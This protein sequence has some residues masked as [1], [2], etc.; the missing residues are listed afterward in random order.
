MSIKEDTIGIY[1]SSKHKNYFL[2]ILRIL[3]DHQGEV[4]IF[5]QEEYVRDLSDYRIKKNKYTWVEKNK[6]ESLS[7]FLTRA[8]EIWN[9]EVN[10]LLV[11]PINASVSKLYEYYSTQFECTYV[12][13]IYNINLWTGNNYRFTHR[14]DWYLSTL[15]RKRLL[16]QADGVI[17]EYT[18]MKKYIKSVS[19]IQNCKVFA[20]IIFEGISSASAQGR[21]TIPGHIEP[22]RRNY[23][24]FIN[25]LQDYLQGYKNKIEIYLLGSP[26][27]SAGEAITDQCE[28]MINSGWNIVYHDSWISVDHFKRI[29]R[30]SDLFV[31]PLNKYKSIGPVRETYGQSKGSGVFGDAV[32]YGKP[33]MLPSY[34]SIPTEVEPIARSYTEG[35][36]LADMIRSCLKSGGLSKEEKKVIQERFTIGEQRK[37]FYDIISTI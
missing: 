29:L 34:Y 17:V 21:V 1:V 26:S 28:K 31:S 14:V 20:P 12:Q 13:M 9:A 6:N 11:F 23:E 15:L 27:D 3:E 7:S 22:E 33:L 8:S 18:P 5:T 24:F 16:S 30:E 19:S 36:E 35:E 25:M 4:I 32:R 2:N 37:R 10:K